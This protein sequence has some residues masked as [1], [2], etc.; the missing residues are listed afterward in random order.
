MPGNL[1][2][3]F[4]SE[5]DLA[6]AAY[7]KNDM[8]R[9][10]S[11]FERAHIL[12]QRYW[13]SHVVTHWWMLK[14]A[15]RRSDLKEIF[16]QVLR[17]IA[18]IPG[19]LFG[20]VPKGNTGGSN[21][22]AIKPMVIPD[23]LAPF[24]DDYNVKRDVAIRVPLV[25]LLSLLGWLAYFGQG[26]W[27]RMGENREVASNFSGQCNKLTGVN[28]PEDIVLDAERRIAYAVG[29]D[30]R[31]FRS[32]GPGRAKIWAIDLDNSGSSVPLDITPST[33][34]NFRSYG[35]AM[36]VDDGG[37][38]RLF[39]ANR[40]DGQHTIEV[41]VIGK[42]NRLE[43]EQTL[44][45]PLLKNPN[46]LVALGPN[47]VLVT[48]DK[49]A[50]AGGLAEILEGAFERPSGKVLHLSGVTAEIVA[51]GLLMANGIVLNADGTV[52]YVG[53]T[54]GQRLSVFDRDITSNKLRFNRYVPVASGVD[55]LSID[56]NGTVFIAGHPKLLTL[57][58]GYQKSENVPSPSEVIAYEPKEGTVRRV[59][60][61]NGLELSGGSVAIIDKA[62]G[63]MLIGSAFGPHI[64]NCVFDRE[65]IGDLL[66]AGGHHNA[67]L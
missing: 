67:Q 28:A 6:R 32:G 52:L 42:N 41:F 46:D 2:S 48:L 15:L 34:I 35:M 58:M 22:S 7:F 51:D 17:I 38:R 62:S 29:G 65:N 26:V 49:E 27:E 50:D 10:F 59:Y 1:K 30:R 16:G 47:E 45:H 43:H 66:G 36:H 18:T 39:V 21:V 3:A 23:D 37:L 13:L 54:V 56:E 63:R 5:M 31:S 4:K 53:E 11:L 8:N 44:S 55:N 14:I 20:W 61:N 12:G 40:P 9:A 57:A 64:L 33:P 24:L 25:I 19:Y 60:V